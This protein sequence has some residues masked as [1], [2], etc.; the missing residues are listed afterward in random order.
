M[1]NQT[2][3]SLSSLEI[4]ILSVPP[5][6]AGKQTSA[7]PGQEGDTQG[8]ACSWAPGLPLIPEARGWSHCQLSLEKPT[9]LASI[10]KMATRGNHLHRGLGWALLAQVFRLIK[11]QE[12]LLVPMHW[13]IMTSFVQVP[14]QGPET[15][16]SWVGR[17][18]LGECR[19]PI[20]RKKW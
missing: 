20:G 1:P 15:N 19:A 18:H 16:W 6:A 12:M 11:I 8:M 4:E 5:W 3:C 2:P 9:I 13:A 14:H 10:F 7:L 17:L